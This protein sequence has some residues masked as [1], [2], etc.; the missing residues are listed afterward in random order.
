MRRLALL[1]PALLAFAASAQQPARKTIPIAIVTS[2]G[3]IEAE[4]DSAHAP[5]TVTN[6]L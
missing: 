4:L 2:F 3:T 5:I 6:F 1:L